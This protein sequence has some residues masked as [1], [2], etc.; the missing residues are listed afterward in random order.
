MYNVY[1]DY[2][3]ERGWAHERLVDV[4][5]INIDKIEIA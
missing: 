3:G 1:N 4:L 2:T 5:E